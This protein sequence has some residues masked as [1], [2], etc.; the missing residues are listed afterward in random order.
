MRQLEHFL[1]SSI[2]ASH[3]WFFSGEE[4]QLL[5][6]KLQL[7][8]QYVVNELWQHTK[9][10]EDPTVDET[11]G[12][13]IFAILALKRDVAA[14]TELNWMKT[15]DNYLA[16][17]QDYNRECF[18][19]V[20]V[21]I[22]NRRRYAVQGDGNCFYRAVVKHF[23]VNVVG[24]VES[25]LAQELRKTL[26]QPL[27]TNESVSAST[28]SSEK[29]PY[30]DFTIDDVTDRSTMSTVGVWADHVQVKKMADFLQR[31]IWIVRHDDFR[32]KWLF[33]A[34]D[35]EWD[36]SPGPEYKLLPALASGNSSSGTLR[37]LVLF[38][39]PEVHYDAFLLPSKSPYICPLAELETFLTTE[40]VP[41]TAKAHN[42]VHW[43]FD[44]E[45]DLSNLFVS[46][47]RALVLVDATDENLSIRKELAKIAL[48]TLH[49][50]SLLVHV[51]RRTMTEYPQFLEQTSACSGGA[52]TALSVRRLFE[53]KL[54][55]ENPLVK[56][57][58]LAPQ[59]LSLS[60]SL[61]PLGQASPSAETPLSSIFNRLTTFFE[62]L[63]SSTLVK[64][65]RSALTESQN[66]AAML[67][68]SLQ[69]DFDMPP[70]AKKPKRK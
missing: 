42:L 45:N 15:V 64:R 20:M 5:I 57:D 63:T 41:V 24:S 25:Q 50:F 37:P 35:G 44:V 33:K 39:T 8:I 21:T 46:H 66:G 59:V 60:F 2:S 36:V 7:V 4:T 56:W 13:S 70:P 62:S 40:T 17:V 14:I 27:A 49:K 61:A 55:Y 51:T 6:K 47:Q 32:L 12:I 38:F 19:D 69:D 1:N 16:L 28:E 11:A 34:S 10:G 31:P 53:D 29:D 9:L 22:T 23:W 3:G 52:L 54:Q 30:A 18:R 26:N 68:A 65:D 67:L 43:W 58:S 48:T